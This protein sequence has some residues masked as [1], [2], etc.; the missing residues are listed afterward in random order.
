[1]G[2]AVGEELGYLLDAY[3]QMLGGSRLI[4]GVHKRIAADNINAEAAVMKEIG[5]MAEAFAAMEDEYLSA[6]IADIREV[7]RRLVQSLG[8]AGAPT[9]L[10]ALPRNAI[11]IADELSP[12]DTALLDPEEVIGLAT[13]LGGVESHTAIVARSLGIPAVVAAADMMDGVRQ[14]RDRHHRRHQR[15][16]DRR[17]LGR[18][19]RALSAQARDLPQTAAVAQKAEDRRRR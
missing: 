19:A 18:D 17:A 4:R 7:G 3:Q 11:I 12:A 6:R 2:G 15:P 1:M 5:L 10:E 8:N 14:R 16:A 13:M 9:G